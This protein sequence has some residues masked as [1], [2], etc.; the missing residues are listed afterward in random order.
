MIAAATTVG[1][2]LHAVHGSEWAD[3][4]VNLTA[5]PL[6]A[7]LAKSL[8]IQGSVLNSAAASKTA[9]ARIPDLLRLDV[10]ALLV[11][12]WKK[13][14]EIEGYADRTKYGPDETVFVELTRHIVTSSHKPTLDIVVDGVT[15]DTVP[16]ELK[17]TLTLDA[18]VL[19]I[20]DGQILAVSPGSGKA[21]GELKC[22]GLSI[23]KRELTP[24]KLPGT[25]TFKEPIPITPRTP[26][27]APPEV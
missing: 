19:T 10:G 5:G 6:L 24:V 18:A 4:L 1:Q 2:L 27:P 26:A 22:E 21:G 11:S 20:R 8:S 13:T 16:F 15:I 14:T 23:L 7:R 9:A 3:G 25:W 12:A 17:V